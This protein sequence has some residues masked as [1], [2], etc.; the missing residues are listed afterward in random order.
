MQRLAAK[1]HHEIGLLQSFTHTIGS[2]SCLGGRN[3]SQM[4][5]CKLV[6]HCRNTADSEDDVWSSWSRLGSHELK[7]SIF[8]SASTSFESNLRFHLSAMLS[9]GPMEEFKW[10]NLSNQTIIKPLS[11]DNKQNENYVSWILI[12]HNFMPLPNV[13][14]GF[15]FAD[16]S[17]N[18]S[19]IPQNSAF[20]FSY[21]IPFS[22]HDTQ[23]GS[24]FTKNNPP[25]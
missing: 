22:Y 23:F 18:P 25:A 7:H 17:F 1:Q 13:P 9:Q 21:S 8:K 11:K 19:L 16:I 3:W 2:Y 4:W 15:C 24:P 5:F 20:H 6:L 14:M 10:K 12:Y